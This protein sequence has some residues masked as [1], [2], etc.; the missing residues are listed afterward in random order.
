VPAIRELA[1]RFD[2]RYKWLL[3]QKRLFGSGSKL[4]EVET[5]T[6]FRTFN[7]TD[8]FYELR[9]SVSDRHDRSEQELVQSFSVTLP[10]QAEWKD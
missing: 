2:G 10:R 3:E 5:L 7:L 9:V 6:P 4:A 8:G 1:N